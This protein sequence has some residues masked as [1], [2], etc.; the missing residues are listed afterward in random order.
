MEPK[1]ILITGGTGF[2][3][4]YLSEMLIKKGH[5]I[6]IVTRSPKEYA[7]DQAQNQK[8]IGWDDVEESIS[9]IDIVINLV[10]ENIFG[11]R[12]T[13]SVKEKIYNSRIDST[14]K[15]VEAMKNSSKKPDLLISASGIGVYGD[16]GDKVIDE[17]S[18]FGDDFLAEVCKDWEVEAQKAEELGVRVAI[19]RFG[20][21]LEEDGGMVEIMK[22]P[23]TLFAGGPVGTG[24]QFVP[25]VHMRDLCKAVI[26]PIS[27]QE[28]SGPYNVCSPEPETMY[29]VAKAFGK[30]MNRPS[31]FKV[32]EP[33]I[34]LL[35]GEA[36][37]PIISSIRAQPKVLQIKDF[38]FEFED[39][40][41]ALA[42]IL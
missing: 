29:T 9:E 7:E 13:K 36:S 2:I 18:S 10:G 4:S 31:F 15:L 27:D 39:L 24:K 38:Q 14:R 41:E 42:D 25:W 1:K 12:W 32:P 37:I 34:K 21:V 28:L 3:G 33:V 40:N 30:V 22:I 16:S 6:T 23:F 20:V 5:Y 17:S 19:P 11:K 8:F 26:L 35:L